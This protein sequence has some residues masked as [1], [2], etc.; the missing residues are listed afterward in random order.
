MIRGSEFTHDREVLTLRAE[1]SWSVMALVVHK[2]R[3]RNASRFCRG[4]FQFLFVWV[5]FRGRVGFVGKLAV[6]GFV[7]ADWLVHCVG[8]LAATIVGE[9]P[10]LVKR[11]GHVIENLSVGV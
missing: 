1:S 5:R 3:L 4:P 9:Q 10:A 8:S 6:S 7:S 11:V 2:K